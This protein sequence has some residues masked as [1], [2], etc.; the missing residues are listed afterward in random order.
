MKKKKHFMDMNE[1]ELQIF[2]MDMNKTQLHQLI[3]KMKAEIIAN[4]KRIKSLKDSIDYRQELHHRD[5]KHSRK[6]G[7]EQAKEIRQWK[8]LLAKEILKNEE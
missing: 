2:V 7:E 5:N 1:E 4:E 8:M 6:V 3:A